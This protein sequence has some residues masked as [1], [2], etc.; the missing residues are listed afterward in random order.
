MKLTY[1]EING[2]V[3]DNV[4]A[5]NPQITATFEERK[6]IIRLGHCSLLLSINVSEIPS[7]THG[8]GD[9]NA[10][11]EMPLFVPLSGG[12]AAEKDA[13]VTADAA[14]VRNGR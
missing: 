9:K 5:S 3:S 10:V 13:A 2:G 11:F 4:N 12:P 7:S 14:V 8:K 1:Y 6:E